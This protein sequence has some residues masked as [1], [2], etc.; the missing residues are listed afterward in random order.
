MMQKHKMRVKGFILLFC[1]LQLG[2]NL[3]AQQR[4]ISGTVRDTDG[5]PIIGASVLVKGTSHGT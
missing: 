4:T 5:E 1:L 3:Y 2:L